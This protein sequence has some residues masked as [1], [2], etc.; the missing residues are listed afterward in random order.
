MTTLHLSVSR[1]H[2]GFMLFLWLKC[3]AVVLF[4][5]ALFLTKNASLNGLGG[6]PRQASLHQGEDWQKLQRPGCH[7][8]ASVGGE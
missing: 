1:E 2:C 5:V 8:R 6:L 4:D 7:H 3:V